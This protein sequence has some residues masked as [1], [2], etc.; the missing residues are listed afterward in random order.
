MSIDREKLGKIL[1][2]NYASG[3]VGQDAGS[4][5]STLRK[6]VKR[7]RKKKKDEMK[8]DGIAI[9]APTHGSY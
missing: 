2:V 6:G 9:P 7:R 1:Q 5:T 8:D 3:V 4:D